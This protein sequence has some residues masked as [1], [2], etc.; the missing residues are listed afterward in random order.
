MILN[1]NINFEL[2]SIIFLS[3]LLIIFGMLYDLKISVNNAYFKLVIFVLLTGVLDVITAFTIDNYLMVDPLLNTII[4]TIYLIAAITSSF[5][6]YWFVLVYVNGKEQFKKLTSVNVAILIGYVF[7]S[8]INVFTGIL[9]SFD[10]YEGYV[11]G[12]LF[13]LNYLIPLYY[14]ICG[15]VVY[16]GNY[17]KFSIKESV[18]MVLC[19]V[20]AVSGSLI[21]L[22]VLPEVLLSVFTLSISIF[23]MRIFT[24]DSS[25]QELSRE[26]EQLKADKEDALK[27]YDIAMEAN[28]AKT[29]FLSNMSHEIRTPIN[30]VMGYNELV[31]KETKESRTTEYSLNIQAAGQTILSLVNDILDF[32]NIDGGNLKIE[33]DEYSVLSLLQ[34]VVT[35]VQ[36]NT[37]KK[38]LELK[39]DIDEK[40]PKML[41]GDMGHLVQIFNNLTANAVKYTM[42]GFVEVSVHWTPKDEKTGYMEVFVKDTGIGMK[43]E[44]V[45][46]IQDSLKQ[47]DEK[48]ARNIPGAGLGLP[49]VMKLLDLMNSKLDIQSV[50]GNGSIFS[51]RVLQAV[52]D[53]KPIG[54]I[55]RSNRINIIAQNDEEVTFYAPKARILAVDDNRMNLDYVCE[56]LKDTG[57]CV[58]TAQNGEEALSLLR[59]NSYHMVLLDHIM[60]ILDGMETLKIIQ[61]EHICDDIPVIAI[62]ANAA[63][64]EKENYIS[65]GFTDYMAKP[66]NGRQLKTLILKYLPKDLLE[67]K[68]DGEVSSFLDELKEF[69]DVNTGMTYCCNSEDFYKE[70][71][72]T[73]VDNNKVAELEDCFKEEDLEN[74]RIQVH[75]LKSTSMSI[76][77]VT[78]SEAAKALEMAAKEERVGYIEEHH[79]EVVEAYKSLLGE[80]ELVLTDSKSEN[81][82]E[83][84]PEDAMDELDEKPCILVV[85][86]SAIN[87]RSAEHMLEDKFLV[88]SMTSGKLALEFLEK[89]LP[90]LILLDLHMPEMDGFEVMERIQADDRYKDIP[91]VF[92]TADDDRDTEIK[93]FQMGALD[94]IKKPFV[95]DIMIQRI[96]RILELDRLQKRLQ[97][98]VLKQTRK[99]EGRRR[100]VERLSLQMVKTL[101]GTIDAKDKYTNGHSER[102]AEYAK[103]IAKRVGKS[104]KEQ[105]DIYYMG[106]LHDIGK[107]GVPDEIINKTSR[108]TDEEYEIIKTHPS[109]GADILKNVSEMPDIAIGAHWHHERF[110]GKGYPDH[111]EGKNIPEIARI[112]GVADAYDAMTSNRSY[113]DV[114]PQEVVRSEIKKGKGTQFDPDFADVMLRMIDEDTDYLMRER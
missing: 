92:L 109:I 25:H 7:L 105:E 78:L 71:L 50:Y 108:L 110:D 52:V 103:E 44:E 84:M 40:L 23:L 88:H 17:K 49:I 34:D 42:E 8:V 89:T 101:A 104:Q 91:V 55:E 107:I 79:A 10:M 58:D 90:D 38:N 68:H 27:A 69:L 96:N 76:G 22:F 14:I 24:I 31:I 82:L 57:V 51:F 81:A 106:L 3:L 65:A 46:K 47:Y 77:A 21:Q 95:A 111:L 48:S 32:T 86:D 64:G 99:A 70:M 72:T 74:Y 112:I 94:F 37:E 36:F 18:L 41:S 113:R 35:Y 45:Q 73:Y 114:L 30:A 16:A 15:G 5:F 67:E 53:E 9:Y 20:V 1:Y 26:V 85:D 66:V 56:A 59:N 102:V 13:I 11:P 97:Q 75:A 62:T 54:R 2:S 93:G 100:K 60:P 39:V 19:M 83:E 98:E 80:L 28:Q 33:R 63:I 4:N 12:Y 29:D 87:L 6:L 43:E 61:D